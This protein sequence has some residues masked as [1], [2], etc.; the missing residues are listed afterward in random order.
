MA[1]VAWKPA[2]WL[3]RLLLSVRV[4]GL[5]PTLG[6][7]WIR[8]FGTED[9]CVFV[10]YF[11]PPSAPVELPVEANGLVVRRMTE[12]DRRDARVRRY[13]PDDVNHLAEGFVATRHSQIVGAAWYT[14][15]VTT[16]QPWYRAVEPHLVFPAWLD[17]NIFVVPG[18]KGAAWAISKTAADRLGAAG[19]CSTVAL[20]GAH[21]RRS[22]L[23]LRFVGAKM[24][25]R[26]SVRHW[27]GHTTTV[28]QSVTDDHDNAV[29]A[30][31]AADPRNQGLR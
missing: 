19:I 1:T 4:D 18:D 16:D 27:F 5:R 6:R 28:V 25:A 31:R 2:V 22:I 10:Q 8:L 14:D 24:V 17:A 7:A 29:T 26:L 11:K 21:N 9:R 15:S 23:L 12:S 20:V 30:R 13:E 3:D